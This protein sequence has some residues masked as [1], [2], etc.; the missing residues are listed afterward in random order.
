MRDSSIPDHQIPPNTNIP[1]ENKEKVQPQIHNGVLTIGENSYDIMI[2]GQKASEFKDEI[3]GHIEKIV[4]YALDSLD[5]TLDPRTLAKMTKMTIDPQKIKYQTGNQITVKTFSKEDSFVKNSFEQIAKNSQRVSGKTNEET[6]SSAP[7]SGA[8]VIQKQQKTDIVQKQE[9]TEKSPGDFLDDYLSKDK[10]TLSPRE[11]L[12]QLASFSFPIE[13]EEVK[14]TPSEPQ[15]MEEPI[16]K[17]ENEE[18]KPP[19]PHSDKKEIDQP[20]D[21]FTEVKGRYEKLLKNDPKF[22]E[23]VIKEFGGKK[24]FFEHL[25][26]KVEAK[27]EFNEKKEGIL[28]I[29]REG[30]KAASKMDRYIEKNGGEK[31]FENLSREIYDKHFIK[32]IESKQNEIHDISNQ[33]NPLFS[34]KDS[35]KNEEMKKNYS[36]VGALINNFSADIKIIYSKGFSSMEEGFSFEKRTGP[37]NSRVGKSSE[38]KKT[39]HK[40]IDEVEKFATAVDTSTENGSISILDGMRNMET[41]LKDLESLKNNT[42]TSW[43]SKAISNSGKISKRLDDLIEKSQNQLKALHE[44]IKIKDENTLISILINNQNY[45]EINETIISE[46]RLYMTP[47]QFIS[48]YTCSLLEN[49][50]NL[51]RS[52]NENDLAKIEEQ[53]IAMAIKAGIK[54]EELTI[55]N[56]PLQKGLIEREIGNKTEEFIKN[57]T[58]GTKH[59]YEMVNK[60]FKITSVNTPVQLSLEQGDFLDGNVDQIAHDIFAMDAHNLVNIDMSVS[61]LK[62]DY[63]KKDV[64]VDPHY[65]QLINRFNDLT[66]LISQNILNQDRTSSRTKAIEN[67]IALSNKLLEIGDVHSAYA[68]FAPLNQ[69]HTQNTRLVYSWNGISDQSKKDYERLNKTFSTLGNFKTFRE[70]EN[71]IIIQSLSPMASDIGFSNE[72]HS[73]N[74]AGTDDESLS[75]HKLNLSNKSRKWILNNVNR[76]KKKIVDNDQVLETKTNLG[77]ILT[78]FKPLSEK[79]LFE[80]SKQVE[81]VLKDSIFPF[82]TNKEG[83]EK[84]TEMLNNSVPEFKIRD[85]I[86]QT[87]VRSQK[88]TGEFIDRDRFEGDIKEIFRFMNDAQVNAKLQENAVKEN[89]QKLIQGN[90]EKCPEVAKKLI[91]DLSNSKGVEDLDT[92]L[93]NAIS[94]NKE[95]N[96]QLIEAMYDPQLQELKKKLIEV[97]SNSKNIQD[98]S[99][100]LLKALSENTKVQELKSAVL[101]EMLKLQQAMENNNELNQ[102]QKLRLGDL[103]G[104]WTNLSELGEPG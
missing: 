64:T 78:N 62:T 56:E 39:L 27:Q 42:N 49:L 40:I 31:F 25:K 61:L 63:S 38:A 55:L 3:G 18:V 88:G 5:N 94:D 13:D 43:L 36:N 71:S 72:V 85:G 66:N 41:I 101:N 9:K 82:P 14:P 103:N 12:D 51:E 46:F 75:Y 1:I 32:L 11:S 97:F 92:Q 83:L 15:H 70:L 24:E 90:K 57:I 26:V 86:L 53:V 65:T 58:E 47:Q 2:G 30:G 102:K 37:L 84:I 29:L 16:R 99:N 6:K 10:S 69:A 68:I 59:E 22:N 100:N 79:K 21:K 60:E 104:M 23:R 89:L 17:I 8:I 91:Q 96:S 28:N 81:P 77:K 19:E 54:P 74:N 48:K 73:K 93:F 67:T 44:G 20:V 45:P 80:L 87:P 7:K 34:A 35:K 52:L 4:H 95:T 98:Q 33:K 76:T 50:D